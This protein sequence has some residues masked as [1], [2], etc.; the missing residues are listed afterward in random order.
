M[1][2][3][4]CN[5]PAGEEV[6]MHAINCGGMTSGCGKNHATDL[7]ATHIGLV[8]VDNKTRH[9]FK[10]N[11]EFVCE[12]GKV[13]VYCYNPCGEENNVEVKEQELIINE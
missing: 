3:A 13:S 12:C 5:I 8:V 10:F 11:N 9:A 1:N 7:W 2:C 6:H 4:L